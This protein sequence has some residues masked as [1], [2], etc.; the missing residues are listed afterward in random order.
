M[1]DLSFYNF[2]DV[3]FFTQRGFS[4]WSSFGSRGHINMKKAQNRSSLFLI[5]PGGIAD[6]VGIVLS[7]RSFVDV[8]IKT[9]VYVG[10]F[11]RVSLEWILNKYPVIFLALAKRLTSL[12]FKLILHIDFALE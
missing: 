2:D 7:Y 6:Y 8:T 12:L 3:S 4:F 5:K 11:P 1:N 10:F 9:N